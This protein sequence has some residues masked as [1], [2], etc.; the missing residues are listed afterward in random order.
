[1]YLG[2]SG[3]PERSIFWLDPSGKTEPLHPAA[4]F[5]NGLQFSPDG[6]RLV[7][8]MGDVLATEDIWI[9][10]LERN[11]SVRLTSLAGASH[12]PLVVSG[13]QVHPFCE[14]AKLQHL[15]GSRGW[16]RRAATVGE[17]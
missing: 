10:D 2:G 4:G 3:E 13:W 14:P 17:G 5:Y 15:S 12:V 9:Q 6:K 7:F 8:G 1:M 16:G 11:T